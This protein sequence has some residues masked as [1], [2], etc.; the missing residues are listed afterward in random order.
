M[1]RTCRGPARLLWALLYRGLARAYAMYAAHGETGAS[2][3]LRGSLATGEVLAGLTDIDV[4]VVLAGSVDV[5]AARRRVQRRFERGQRALPVIGELL[6]DWPNVF[7]EG[8]LADVAAHTVFTYGLGDRPPRSA[9]L[10]SHLNAAGRR[11][12]ERPEL[13]GPARSWRRLNG[14]D[15]LPGKAPDH[16][17]ARRLG[18]WLE[19]QDWW[20]WAFDACVHP[21]RPRNAHLCVKVVAE[22][23]RCWLWLVDGQ[24]VDSRI[25][26]LERGLERLP[27]HAEDFAWALE[28]A[29]GLAS[30]RRA[31]L[32]SALPRL[33]AL[34][35]LVARE[36]ARG[37]EPAGQTEVRLRHSADRRLAF[38]DG[39]WRPAHSPLLGAPPPTLL[40]LVDW[41]ALAAGREVDETFAIVPGNAADPAIVAAIATAMDRGPYPTLSTHGL[42]IRP[43][44]MGGRQTLR[45]VQCPATDPV[46]FALAADASLAMFPNVTGWS[47]EDT[48][49]RAVAEH[50]AWLAQRRGR[51]VE[52]D[53]PALSVLV[54]AARAGLLWQSVEAGE[55]ELP[56]TADATLESL[57]EILPGAVAI[58]DAAREVYPELADSWDPP[59]P[60]LLAALREAVER[61]PAYASEQ[62]TAVPAS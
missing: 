4:E 49:R 33:L 46:S 31:P 6:F 39:D 13:Y 10:G 34:S 59:A 50:A 8:E 14:P 20:R 19:L 58:A 7:E 29:R 24:R 11:L 27:D 18:A 35:A 25:E 32:G 41:R 57:G 37:I 12:L 26:A 3:Y 22:P 56:L 1:L 28:L 47:I 5:D 54:T 2:T 60:S 40:P 16:A 45:A 9:Y 30:T 36:I 15:R 51:P 44:P 21:H 42:L 48:A 17:D 62:P 38:P 53:F 52:R 23:V 55:P 61:L 43:A